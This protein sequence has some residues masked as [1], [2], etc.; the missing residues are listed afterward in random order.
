MAEQ[1]NYLEPSIISLILRKPKKNVVYIIYRT[2][3]PKKKR[4]TRYLSQT[5]P[6]ADSSKKYHVSSWRI[7]RNGFIL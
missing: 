3:I 4:K 1:V 6:G 2:I 7:A 5:P